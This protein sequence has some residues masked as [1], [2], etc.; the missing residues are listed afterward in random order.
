MNNETLQY[1]ITKK[2][3]IMMKELTLKKRAFLWLMFMFL[4]TGMYAQTLLYEENMGSPSGTT[5]VQNY[6]GWQ[7][8]EVLYIGDG[9]CDIRISSASNGYGLASGG[10]NVMLNDTV[11]WFQIS[12]VST[13]TASNPNLYLGIRKTTAFDGTNLLVQVSSDSVSWT[14]MTIADTLPTG[15]G[16]SGWYRVHYDGLPVCAKLHLRFSNTYNTD[17]RIDDIAVVDGNET[18]LETVETPVISPSSG[19]YYEPQTVTISTTTD[20]A[21]IHYTTDGTVPNSESPIYTAPFSSNASIVVKAFAVKEGMY[22]SEV[23]TSNIQIQDTNSLVLLPFDISDNSTSAHE[24][25]TM[26][27]GFRGYHLGSSYADGSAKFEATHAGEATLVAHLDSAPEFLSFDLK[28]KTG[29]SS[30]ASYEGVVMELAE[31]PDSQTWTI[32]A[33]FGSPDIPLNEYGHYTGMTLS[34]DTRY[35]RWR[36]A[37]AIKGNTQLNNI[38]IT[39]Y[40]GPSDSTAVLDYLQYPVAC[41]PNPTSGQLFF[42]DGG[43]RILSMKLTNICGVE[44]KSWTAPVSSPLNLTSL[45]AGTYL[46]TIQTTAGTMHTKV[47]KY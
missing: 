46:L 24:D 14:T 38:V 26:M 47:T 16:T 31:S 35:V 20:E 17:C 13:A 8:Q 29:G 5:L 2:I 33:S 32:F 40:E 27:S 45:P 10:G 21:V 1:C 22:D 11:K 36:L 6:T 4:I 43:M 37:E 34:P 9:T 19:L 23:V 30:P 15:T 25:I 7:N 3:T 28:G 18:V 12:G 42:T 41:Y 39:K 44:V